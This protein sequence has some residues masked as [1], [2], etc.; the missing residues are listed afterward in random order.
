MRRLQARD[1]K[2]KL[3]NVKRP[4]LDVFCFAF[5]APATILAQL[6]LFLEGVPTQKDLKCP[7]D[8]PCVSQS[9]A[10]CSPMLSVA[11]VVSGL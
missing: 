8:G 11:V 3:S 2:E 1:L 10:L 9:I 6:W 5:F 4:N 7:S